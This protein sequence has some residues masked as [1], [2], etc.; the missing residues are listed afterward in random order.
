MRSHISHNFYPSMTG[1]NE[2]AGGGGKSARVRS[3][4]RRMKGCSGW[5]IDSTQ[6]MTRLKE[7]VAIDAM[8][9]VLGFPLQPLAFVHRPSQRGGAPACKSV[10]RCA[11]CTFGEA[12]SEQLGSEPAA[13]QAQRVRVWL[14]GATAQHGNGS[15][16]PSLPLLTPIPLH[17][18]PSV[19]TL[20]IPSPRACVVKLCGRCCGPNSSA[21][22]NVS[23]CVLCCVR[24]CVCKCVC[25]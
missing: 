11:A 16:R 13:G 25:G 15:S 23:V 17:R 7:R 1:L 5:L 10:L 6:D 24:V 20:C 3:S 4:L 21:G 14:E 9:R 8:L 12:M 18:L 19:C 2:T 22:N